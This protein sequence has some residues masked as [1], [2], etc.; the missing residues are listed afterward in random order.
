MSSSLAS[1]SSSTAVK[2]A[3]TASLFKSTHYPNEVVTARRGSPLLIGVK[4]DKKLKVDFVDVDFA[5]QDNDA[6]VDSLQP[7]LPGSMLVPPTISP[8]F[9]RTQSHTFMSEDGL[10]QPIKFYIALDAAAVIEH[11]KCVL[12]L[13]DN[14][15]HIAEGKLHIHRL[16]RTDSDGKEQTAAQA[17]HRHH[18]GR[19]RMYL[20]MMRRCRHILFIACGTSYHSCLATRTIFEELTEIPVSVELA[21][22]FLDRKTPI[23]RDDMC[24][25]QPERGDGGHDFGAA[26]IVLLLMALQLSEDRISFSERQNQII[27]RLHTMRAAT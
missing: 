20:P 19:L 11:T 3:F 22:D 17:A 26:Y 27:D 18:A 5:R 7:Q 25:P 6:K 8:K 2:A 1:V 9:L 16:R 24:V 23:F 4:T 10:P 13:E 15:A 14:I 21:A 12:Y